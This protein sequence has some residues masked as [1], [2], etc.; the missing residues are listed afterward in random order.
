MTM[1]RFSSVDRRQ[2]L[3]TAGA[4]AALAATTPGLLLGEETK[5]A[6]DAKAPESL[7]KHLYD[8]MNEKQKKELCL[9][10]DHTDSRGLLRTRVQNNWH[11]TKPVI[12]SDYFTSDQKHLIRK[13]FEGIVSEEWIERFDRQLKD[14]AGGFGND[15]N[16]AI[17]GAPGEDKYELVMTGRHMTVRCDGDSAEHVAFGGPIF[18]GHAAK[19]FNE[20]P[21]HPNNVFWHQAVAANNVYKML[22]GKQ[23]AQ[24]LLKTAPFEED[25]KFQGPEGK[26]LGIKVADLSSDQKEG[27]QQVLQTLIAP[28]R[29][30]DRDEVVACL[31]KNGGLDEC[32][33]A[34]FKEGDIGDDKVWDIWRLEGPTFVW[35]YRG[36]PHVHCWVNVADSPDVATNTA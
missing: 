10:W 14:D 11:I 24:A 3:K 17:F 22:D 1:D 25:V 35:H 20:K 21:E 7:V 5:P 6:T 4:G 28:Y 31:K 30:T 18:Y 27:V 36:S 23:Q 16:I 8:T 2:F 19:G 34:F 29:Q 15:Q 33:L 12:N 9:P 26:F 32:R 13:I